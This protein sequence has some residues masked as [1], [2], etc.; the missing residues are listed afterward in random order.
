MRGR[1]R[2]NER[3]RER[4]REREIEKETEREQA[5]LKGDNRFV[6]RILSSFFDTFI[7]TD[8]TNTL[9]GKFRSF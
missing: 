6:F 5:L 7:R 4:E 9:W 8:D 1:G 2:K 3:K